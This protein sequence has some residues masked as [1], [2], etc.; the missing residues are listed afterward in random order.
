[1]KNDLAL[2]Y[3]P[4]NLIFMCPN[5][6]SSRPV[7]VLQVVFFVLFHFFIPFN[8]LPYCSSRLKTMDIYCLILA[9]NRELRSS[10]GLDLLKQGGTLGK[11]HVGRMC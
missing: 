11:I 2:Q 5:K 6:S 3:I 9:E 10:G 1:M 7:E 8:Y 4:T